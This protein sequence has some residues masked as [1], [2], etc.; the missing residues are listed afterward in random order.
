[1][2]A[3]HDPDIAVVIPSRRGTRLIRALEAL[4][5]QS[6]DLDR[7]EVVVARDPGSDRFHPP[8]SGRLHVKLM[9]GSRGRGPGA[10]RNAGWMLASAPL[11]AFTD[12]D[13][14]P[15]AG[16]LEALIREHRR[17][18]KAIL[19]GRTEPNPREL[20][21]LGPFARTI[22]VDRL[23][24][25]F[26]TCNMAYPREALD[27]LGG[28]DESYTTV[29]EDTDLAWRA[30]ESGYP[31]AFVS[32]ALVYHAV[33]DLGLSGKL[34]VA[35][36]WRAGP[37]V[38]RD[39]PELREHLYRGL[40]WKRS[41]ALFLA[42]ALGVLGARRTPAALLLALP[43]ARD[44]RARMA[45]EGAAMAQAP[46]YPLHDGVEVAAVARGAARARV[47]VL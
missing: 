44:V 46:F 43:Y 28:F 12:D 9:T 31:V 42:A 37:R 13:C 27:R 20:H 7:F 3:L 35:A 1:M 39:H 10:L 38:F 14:E 17:A 19:Q 41:H 40:F 5:R 29:A 8:A 25:W 47:M 45:A 33:N 4:S 24:P 2:T 11:I 36:R 15:E 32:D 18:P 34:A 22:R 23:G 21:A 26:P 6:L 30:R 16:W